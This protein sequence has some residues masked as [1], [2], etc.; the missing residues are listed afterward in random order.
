MS[1]LLALATQL[2]THDFDPV[3][4]LPPLPSNLDIQTLP[5]WLNGQTTPE[6][7]VEMMLD[8]LSSRVNRTETHLLQASSP[9]LQNLVYGFSERKSVLEVHPE[10]WES[11]GLIELDREYWVEQT[12]WGLESELVPLKL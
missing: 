12:K 9:T 7:D 6:D 5:L 1:Q 3:A 4:S 2:A 11:Q 10:D 8:H